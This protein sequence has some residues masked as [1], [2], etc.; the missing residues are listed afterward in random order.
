MNLALK[1]ALTVKKKKTT[2]DSHNPGLTSFFDDE[3]SV[4][5]LLSEHPIKL[6]KN[7]KG[8]MY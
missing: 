7:L 3:N 1:N 6:D 5:L 4:V 2:N 8:P